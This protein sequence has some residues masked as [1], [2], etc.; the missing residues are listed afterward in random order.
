[1][2]VVLMRMLKP[3]YPTSTLAAEYVDEAGARRTATLQDICYKPFGD[4]CAT[5]SVLQ[6]WQMSRQQYEAERDKK[7]WA[8]KHTPEYCLSHW[9]TECRSTFE[10]P[11]DPKVV[12]G[13]FPT[14]SAFR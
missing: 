8:V 11:I 13:G 7:G 14:G 4:A 2:H 10:A 12:L 5:Q 1:M 3:E 6:Y 9:Y